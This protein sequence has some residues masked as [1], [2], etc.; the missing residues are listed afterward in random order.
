MVKNV[1]EFCVKTQY[2]L[3]RHLQLQKTCMMSKN[4]DVVITL[5]CPPSDALR[6]PILIFPV[7]VLTQLNPH[8]QCFLLF[9]FPLRTGRAVF[10]KQFIVKNHNSFQSGISDV[11]SSENAWISNFFRL[12]KIYTYKEQLIKLIK[13]FSFSNI[14]DLCV[15]S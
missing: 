2:L 15:S 10:G 4:N 8:H 9:N 5:F 13:T 11:P 1:K 12:H 7:P 6:N 14:H 3:G